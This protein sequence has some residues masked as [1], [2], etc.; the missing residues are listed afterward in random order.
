MAKETTLSIYRDYKE[1]FSEGDLNK[2]SSELSDRFEEGRVTI[3]SLM[4][5][6]G[7]SLKFI[8]GDE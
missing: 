7:E 3:I 5:D 1:G 2:L 4:E 6:D 8:L